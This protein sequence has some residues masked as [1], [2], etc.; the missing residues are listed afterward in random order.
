MQEICIVGSGI[1]GL[2]TAYYTLELSPT[3]RVTLVENSLSR[4]IAGGASSQSGGFLAGGKAWHEGLAQDLGR[5]SW[6]E[7][8]A[9]ADKLGGREQYG[10]RESTAAGLNVGGQDEDRSK[11]RTLPGGSGRKK[12]EAKDG[13]SWVEGEREELSTE[14]GVGQVDPAQFCK[15][16]FQHLST[17][18]LDRFTTIFGNV[19]SL[20]SPSSSSSSS[21]RRILSIIPLLPSFPSPSSTSPIHLPVDH[22]VVAAGPWSAAVLAQLSLPS[23][24]LRNLPGHSLLIRPNLTD[25]PFDTLPSA[26]VFAG[27]SGA[28]VGVHASTSGLARHL[29]AAE[30]SAGFTASPEMFTR[31]NGL[32][33]VA[34]ENSIPET[35]EAD[36]TVELSGGRGRVTLLNKLPPTVD[37]VKEMTD[38]ALSAR[39]TRAAGLVSPLL[40]EKKGAVVE[41]RQ[42][43]YRPTT[44][45][46]EPVMGKI[47]PGVWISTGHGP[48]GIT[49]APGSGKVI[50]EQM[51]GLPTSA[52]VAG[53]H[54]RRFNQTKAK[55]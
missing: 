5:L 47:A 14:G 48:W 36:R 29:T 41:K 16:L 40:D 3:T 38:P 53:L 49:Q 45:D 32:V 43:C 2:C 50:A 25:F 12:V 11:Y 54:P 8:V 34:G 42:F 37:E 51:L 18:Y 23:I 21:T 35:G 33:F 31:K 20:S 1:L 15:V 22:L 13:K 28:V 44:P 46:M 52:D 17:A 4:T 19:D 30:K 39:L 7:H 55:L 9:L 6:E 10:F 24:P 27:I 26:A